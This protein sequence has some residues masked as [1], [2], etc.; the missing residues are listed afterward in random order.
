MNLETLENLFRRLAS[1]ADS[2]LQI[3]LE[4]VLIGFAINWCAGVLHGTRGTR[5]LRGLLVLF[6]VA[7]L[8]V[9]LLAAAL[10]W[11]RLELLYRYFL[12]GLAFIALVA[13]Q[14]ELRRALIRAGDVQFM[15][16][17]SPHEKL[18][19][20]LT[21]TAGYLSRHKYG[22]LIAI[23]R[24]IGLA[25]WAENGTTINAEV[26]ANLLKS[27]FYPNN[28]LH[29]LG[30]IIRDGKV[31][32]ANCQFP[33]AESGEIDPSL[34]SRHRAAVGLSAESDALVLVISD[35]TGTISL[36]DRGRLVRFLSLDDLE[37]QL[38][39]RLSGAA[40]GVR[41]RWRIRTLSDVWRTLRRLLIVAPLAIVIW[42]LADQASLIREDGVP[43]ALQIV[44]DPRLHVEIIEPDPQPVF[45]I[46]VRGTTRA[47]E[48]LINA[49]RDGALEARWTLRSPYDQPGAYSPS[50]PDLIRILESLPELR[51]LQLT[52]D[53]VSPR[54]LEFVVNEVEVLQDVP[55][56]VESGDFQ[57]EV[58]EIAPP[59]VEVRVRRADARR[60]AGVEPTAVAP[61]ADQLA[62]TPPG[63]IRT[64]SRVP[65][66]RT[67]D[68]V[69][70]L[71]LNPTNVD[72]T[73]RI[74]S[75]KKR[76]RLEQVPVGQY[77]TN[78]GTYE[79]VVA[80]SE[81]F[82]EWLVELEVEGDQAVVD[83]LTNADPYV[84]V[85]IDSERA[86]PSSEFRPFQ[87]TVLLP[88]GVQLVG[89]PPTVNLRFE[90]RSTD[91]SGP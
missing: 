2:P 40:T 9:Q 67:I 6:V 86:L 51:D 50:G 62:Q 30:V 66:A 32:A 70:A 48:R 63:Q 64:F 59:D 1:G 89:E 80:I 60:L 87:T 19:A 61:L 23:Q 41:G 42:F 28:P 20:A 56:R 44:R 78:P 22:G 21:E 3:I 35:E 38:Q 77:F 45:R 17:M 29:D 11:A 46:G 75:E 37:E 82:N 68:G 57:V 18:I 53:E 12:I 39:E 16:R 52:I 58:L 47:V 74:V 71:G 25:N 31:V 24:E 14:P 81:D 84:F 5:L 8:C 85:K 49:T 72:V 83:K 15:R 13:F 65:L 73:L 79:R 10:D 43:I 90:S 69:S 54:T 88:P 4:L 76:K 7:T 27:I 36:A 33:I 91:G 34:G 55:V 26:S